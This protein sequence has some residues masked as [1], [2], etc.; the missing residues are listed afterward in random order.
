MSIDISIGATFNGL[1]T[2]IMIDPEQK[3]FQIKLGNDFKDW[4]N[5]TRLAD[6]N[7]TT[8]GVSNRAWLHEKLDQFLDKHK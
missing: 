8:L 1:G 2:T 3:S 6:D 4:I 5:D 7:G